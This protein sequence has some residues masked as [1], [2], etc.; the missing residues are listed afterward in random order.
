MTRIEPPNSM[1]VQ[2]RVLTYNDK[3]AQ[4][5]GSVYSYPTYN[6]ALVMFKELGKASNGEYLVEL[7]VNLVEE[8]T[9]KIYKHAEL[10]GSNL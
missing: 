9:E 10:L 4:S 2:Y 8:Y 7:E 6:K 5:L 1:E 3:T